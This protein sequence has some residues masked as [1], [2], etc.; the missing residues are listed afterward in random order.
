MN[1]KS[2]FLFALLFA[3]V[4][5]IRQV[6]A[7]SNVP[8]LDRSTLA[9]TIEA[10][11]A[12]LDLAPEQKVQIEALQ[13]SLRAQSVALREQQ[14]EPAERQAA[15]REMQAYARTTIQSVLTDEQLA[16]LR[17]YRT[18]RNNARGR[19]NR[20]EVSVEALNLSEEQAIQWAELKAQT[21]TE[22]E[23]LRDQD[24]A[25]PA[26]RRT[27]VQEV[28]KNQNDRLKEMLSPEQWKK[29][30]RMQRN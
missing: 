29:L 30:R 25:S 20:L 8:R 14:L 19:T 6:V 23:T 3:S 16:M 12:E 18:D 2:I 5:P 17:E 4:L 27:A 1:Y 15:L 11:L 13:D 9:E 7:Q 22:L 24:F 28:Y 26:D 10:R 21:K